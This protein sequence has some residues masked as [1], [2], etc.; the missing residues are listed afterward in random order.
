MFLLFNTALLKFLIIVVKVSYILHRATI[1]VAPTMNWGKVIFIHLIK[2]RFPCFE[3]I[4]YLSRWKIYRKKNY[5]YLIQNIPHA[6]WWSLSWSG[7]LQICKTYNFFWLIFLVRPPTPTIPTFF[8][9]ENPGKSSKLL[10]LSSSSST[11]TAFSEGLY[12]V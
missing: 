9:N 7:L 3:V 5:A 8:I 11:I 4:Y 10:I 2:K 1:Y 6:Y 12:S